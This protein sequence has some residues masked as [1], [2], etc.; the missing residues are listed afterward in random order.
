M[1]V[2][3]VHN[4]HVCENCLRRPLSRVGG[5]WVSL[6]DHDLCRQCWRSEMESRRA[7]RLPRRRTPPPLPAWTLRHAVQ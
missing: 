6:K 5:R 4:R 2:T 7:R 3:I 1:L